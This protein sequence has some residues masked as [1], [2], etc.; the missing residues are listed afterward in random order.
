MYKRKRIF[1][2]YNQYLQS[3]AWQERRERII[4]RAGG[5]CEK[6]KS[7]QAL[8]VHH[9]TY[10]RIGNERD[11]DLIVLCEQCHGREHKFYTERDLYDGF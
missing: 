10:A 1:G 8:Q 2:T 6:C 3:P 4:K 11:G 9:L 5:C 7:T